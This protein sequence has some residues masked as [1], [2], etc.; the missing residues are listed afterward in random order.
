MPISLFVF[1]F[2]IGVRLGY[3]VQR[4]ASVYDNYSALICPMIK[5]NV[6]IVMK[7]AFPNDAYKPNSLKMLNIASVIRINPPKTPAMMKN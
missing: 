1:F 6:P 5:I 4:I 7:T 2:D 3:L